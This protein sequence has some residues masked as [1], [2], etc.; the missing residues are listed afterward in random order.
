MG[1]YFNKPD[2]QHW[3]SIKRNNAAR[4][5]REMANKR[6]TMFRI[7]EATDFEGEISMY[8]RANL[9]FFR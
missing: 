4:Q 8:E 3:E 5:M 6:V 7:S 1:R 9:W 2:K